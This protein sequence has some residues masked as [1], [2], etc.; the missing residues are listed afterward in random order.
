MEE[1]LKQIWVHLQDNAVKIIVGLLVAAAAWWYGRYRARS[2]W[3]RREFFHRIN[4]SL[5]WIDQGSLRFR[6]LAEQTC[7]DVFLNVVA[8]DRVRAAAEKTTPENPNL[9]L[10]KEEYWY[11]LNG[12]LNTLSEK[13]AEGLIRQEMGLPTQSV[14]YLVCL[15]CEAAGDLRTRKV[16]ALVVRQQ[17]LENLP[18][19]VPAFEHPRHATRWQTLKILAQRFK[20]HPHE[21]IDVQLAI[22][23]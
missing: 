11:F 23:K 22:S 18:E 9:P 4:I 13:F 15:T 19:E 16:R 21:F 3:N 2:E 1:I 20:T 8:A 17:L 5:N 7:E 14:R 6:T 12:V 10:P